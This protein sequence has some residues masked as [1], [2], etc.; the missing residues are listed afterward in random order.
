MAKKNKETKLNSMR[1]LEQRDIPYE[2]LTY[3]DSIKDAESVA[4]MIGVPEF[5]VYKTLIAQSAASAEPYIVMIASDRQLNL[6][7]LA[8]AANEKK[9]RMASQ[10]DAEQLTGL[11]VGGISALM[12]MDKNWSIYL[13]RAATELQNIVIS[14]GQRGLQIRLPVTALMSTI[15][16]RLADLS[17]P[18]SG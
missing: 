6:K 4:E 14:A 1:L 2:V 18:K 15:G 17:E 12:L 3:D 7:K 11:Q 10:A 16:A 5:M 9:M 13:D 8:S